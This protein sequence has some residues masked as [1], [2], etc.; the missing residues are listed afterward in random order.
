MGLWMEIGGMKLRI[1]EPELQLRPAL[2]EVTRDIL[3][4]RPKS[5]G[6]NPEFMFYTIC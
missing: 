2:L 1:P 3:T 6:S 4:A 5:I